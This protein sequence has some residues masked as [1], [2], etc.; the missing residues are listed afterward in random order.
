MKPTILILT[1][2]LSAGGAYA[3]L[4]GQQA[5]GTQHDQ[6]APAAPS[7]MHDMSA[8]MTRMHA[9]DARL[10]QL[11]TKMRAATGAAR[12]DAMAELLTA[13]VEDRKHGCE[14]M[15]AHMLSTMHTHGLPTKP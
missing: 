2:V 6:H 10:E 1:A 14:P 4:H 11:V 9:N 8:M 7:G 15:M 3:V 13:L 12:T 5:A